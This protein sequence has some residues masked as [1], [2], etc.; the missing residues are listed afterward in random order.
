[1]SL[2]Q[3]QTD[4]K[5]FSLMQNQW[6]TQLNPMLSNP[7]NSVLILKNI[8]LI[9]GVTI[10]NHLLSRTQQGWFLTDINAAATIYRSQPF[11]SQTLTLTS[12]AACTVNIGVY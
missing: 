9:N 6:A 1:M 5:D 10:V 11:N 8:A 7:L 4:D 2:P 12:D 3:F